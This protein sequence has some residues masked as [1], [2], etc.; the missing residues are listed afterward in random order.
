MKKA[1]A[2]ILALLTLL[3]TACSGGSLQSSVTEAEE[4]VTALPE[5]EPETEAA[6]ARTL[7]NH[8]TERPNFVLHEGATADE[9]RQMAIKAMREAMCVNWYPAEAARYEY[10]SPNN[11]E[12][13]EFNMDPEETYAGIPY[14]SSYTGLFQ[15]LEYYDFETGMVSVPVRGSKLQSRLSPSAPHSPPISTGSKEKPFSSA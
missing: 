9:M 6:P 2:L 15:F 13:I 3:V 7:A 1:L 12:T 5:T 10:T 11:G 8:L 14:S 4:T